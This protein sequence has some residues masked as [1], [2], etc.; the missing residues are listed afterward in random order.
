MRRQRHGRRVQTKHDARLIQPFS[1]YKKPD[2][3]AR[4][5]SVVLACSQGAEG[6]SAMFGQTQ[7]NWDCAFIYNSKRNRPISQPRNDF[8]LKHICVVGQDTNVTY[9]DMKQIAINTFNDRIGRGDRIP[10][11]T[12]VITNV[13]GFLEMDSWVAANAGSGIT[14]IPVLN[15]AIFTYSP[16]TGVATS[17]GAEV[18]VTVKQGI[19]GRKNVDHMEPTL[20][21]AKDQTRFTVY[22]DADPRVNLLPWWLFGSA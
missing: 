15:G 10:A 13:Q 3:L 7:C 22:S 17:R 5:R 4:C 18:M 1:D 19:D 21:D 20:E 6:G 16:A 9:D 2:T 8:A 14:M 12:I 11:S